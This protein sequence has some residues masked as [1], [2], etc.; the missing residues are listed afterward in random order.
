M[1]ELLTP[2]FHPLKPEPTGLETNG[3]L[4][5]PVRC[6]LCDIY[7][8]LFISGSGDI[9]SARHSNEQK[10][11]LGKLLAR[12]AVP[13]DP[14]QVQDRLR[15]EIEKDHQRAR[16]SGMDFPEV[17]IELLWQTILDW[18]DLE[19]VRAFAVE[20][21][22]IVNPVWPMPGLRALL[23]RCRDLGISLGI[24]SNAQFFTPLLF[25]WFLGRDPVSL[26]FDSV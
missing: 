20:Y 25:E 19:K 13:F 12:Y 8:T 3:R 6:L 26:G 16:A 23:S 1:K 10:V 22:I 5:P 2:Y 4:E 21:E 15:S 11:K 17:R 18:P 24:I 9:G 7:G 14:K